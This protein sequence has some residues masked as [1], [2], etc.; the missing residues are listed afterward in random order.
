MRNLIIGSGEIGKS[1]YKVLSLHHETFIKDV[2]EMKLDNIKVLN[3]CYP[4][5]EDFINI[6]KGS[7]KISLGNLMV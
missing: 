1:L 4:P 5:V 3:I 7:I 6:T 2:E